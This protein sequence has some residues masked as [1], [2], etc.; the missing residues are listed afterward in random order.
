MTSYKLSNG[1]DMPTI[2][3]GTWPLRGEVLKSVVTSAIEVGYRLFDTADNY[4]NEDAL[5]GS[6]RQGHCTKG[7]A[8]LDY[9]NI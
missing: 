8:I 3:M 7:K 1:I 5:G 6:A 2:G 9:E 4:D